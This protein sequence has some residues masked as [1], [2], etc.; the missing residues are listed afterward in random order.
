MA[1]L[2]QWTCIWVNSGNWWWTGR[3]GVLQSVGSQSRTRLSNRVTISHLFIQHIFTKCK[4]EW[5]SAVSAGDAAVKK[6]TSHHCIYR[7]SVL[8]KRPMWILFS[9]ENI[10]EREEAHCWGRALWRT[11]ISSWQSFFRVKKKESLEVYRDQNKFILKGSGQIER[12]EQPASNI[13]K[14]CVSHQTPVSPSGVF[15]SSHRP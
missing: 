1:S 13:L 7:V 2:T 8:V 10:A 6:E 12:Q 4:C 9:M 15:I 14:K 3:P 5:A 11:K